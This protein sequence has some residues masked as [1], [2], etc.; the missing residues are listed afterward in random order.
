MSM[1]MR[2]KKYSL[3]R[4]ETRQQNLRRYAS[5]YSDFEM[6]VYI[7]IY[8]LCLQDSTSLRFVFD[9]D[10]T[11]IVPRQPTSVTEDKLGWYLKELQA[12]ET[13]L[14]L[15]LCKK[16]GES[17]FGSGMSYSPVISMNIDST[18]SHTALVQYETMLR[19]SYKAS[20]YMI[21]ERIRNK[22]M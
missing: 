21:D 19:A 14:K 12:L 16:I 22:K 4:L 17:G 11:R 6:S 8:M 18:L 9:D 13:R 15:S 7:Y 3:F 2:Q 10:D 20:V 5:K 1:E